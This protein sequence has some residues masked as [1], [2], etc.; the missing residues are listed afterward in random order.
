[1]SV[2]NARSFDQHEMLAFGHDKKT[3]LSAIIA[4]HNTHLGPAAGGCRMYPYAD[5]DA[6]LNDVLRLSRGMTYKSA[7]AGLPFGGGKSI[8][9]GDP[10]KDKTPALLRAMGEFIHGLGGR[11]I[12][13]EDSGT[14][15]KDMKVIKEKTPHVVGVDSRSKYLGDPSPSTALGVFTGIQV[16]VKHR[17]DLDELTGVRIAVQGVGQVGYY[18]TELLAE[19]GA[20]VFV[21]DVNKDNVARVSKAFGATAV[22]TEDII[23]TEA[24]VF[25]P[26]ALGAVINDASIK[27]LKAPVIA[28]AAN[29]QLAEERHAQLLLER[30]ILYAP[31]FVI[32][33]GGI[34]DVY[35]QTNKVNAEVARRHILGIGE[36]LTQIF[37]RVDAE[38][39]P[40]H[41]IAE[42]MAEEKLKAPRASPAALNLVQSA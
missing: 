12:A 19:A 41:L 25:S 20:R 6:A 33:A 16:A 8:I 15:V 24:E 40:S 21:A 35:Y 30:G 17:L 34:I 38:G 29:N 4:I 1:M 10:K 22:P 18:L 3:G 39:R 2:F 37:A 23:S 26:C 13:A 36:K 14:S 28:G 9:I 32:N 7:L 27:A 31:D 42:A 5:S 11:Y